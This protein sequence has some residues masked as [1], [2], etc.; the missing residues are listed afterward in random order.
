MFS[1]HTNDCWSEGQSSGPRDQF[2]VTVSNASFEFPK[3]E[4]G[5]TDPRVTGRQLLEA[6]GFR[7]PDEHLIFQ[8]LDNGALEERRLDEIVELRESSVDRFIAFQS[9]RSFRVE[10]DRR[11]F[12]WGMSKLTGLIAKQMVGAEISGTGVWIERR[13]E[14]DLFVKDSDVV[15][16]SG[17]G[18]ERL[19][20]GPVYLLYIE[21]K[22]YQWFE[23][24]ITT[25]QIAELGGWD[26]SDGVQQVDMAT[27]EA[28][29]LEPGEVVNLRKVSTF[30]KKI[31]WQRG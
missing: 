11:R 5:L 23:P 27:N 15:D 31:G 22:Q 24:V 6:A 9:D 3:G 20:V 26:V 10:I 8:V 12:E 4:V 17:N 18:I 21:G 13:D 29:T 19:R 7:P 1:E 14:P 2:R 28:R 16:L 30:A 25:E